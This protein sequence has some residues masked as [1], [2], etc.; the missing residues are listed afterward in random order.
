MTGTENVS[1][2]D[3]VDSV[4][5]VVVVGGGA[6]GLNAALVL[7]RARRRVAVVDAGQPRN[8]PAE[9]MH[10]FLSRD[11]TSPAALLEV[12]RHEVARYGVRLVEGR[13][14]QIEAVAGDG[15]APSF[16]AQLA[17]GP[18]LRARRVLVATGLR[19]ELPAV[20]G[21]RQRWA[22]DVLHCPYCHG[23]E[24][25]DQ[26]IGVLGTAEGSVHQA[27]L[28]SRWSED[29]VF[30]PHTL[31]L[32][33]EDRERFAALGVRVVDGEVTQLV[34]HGDRLRGV[35]MAEGHV[36]TRD[37]LFV[38][39]RM[40]PHDALLT[41]LGCRTGADGW[42]ITDPSGRTSVPGVWAAGNVVD[43]RAQ[44]ITAA[45][46]GAAAAIALNHDLLEEEIAQVMVA[47]RGASA[48]AVR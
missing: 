32:G 22:K 42:V 6:S 30:F 41:T 11:R 26:R 38:A 33:E 17:G 2:K 48:V 28:L 24:V 16:L 3:S 39:P 35:E 8:A 43:Q 21:L 1:A 29:V 10:G 15:E 12:G 31:G 9:H 4:Y 7:G 44:V 25:R 23:Y 37:A 14:D 46:R 47:R 5:D 13:V 19:D 18:V 45:A 36:V 27:L 20:A 34:A 40:V